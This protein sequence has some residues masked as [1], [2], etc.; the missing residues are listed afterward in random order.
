M[1]GDV[2][3]MELLKRMRGL[4][5]DS[6]II[7]VSAHGSIET[8]VA[9]MKLGGYDFIRRPFEVEEIVAGVRNA[10]RTQTLERRVAESSRELGRRFHGIAPEVLG[11]LE[12]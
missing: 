8:A 7:L 9:A 10:V 3:G 4:V 5:P 11:L 12:R 1:L 2:D 6:K